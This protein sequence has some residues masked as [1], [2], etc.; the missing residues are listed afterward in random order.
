MWALRIFLIFLARSAPFLV[1]S[2]L[3]AYLL[4]LFSGPQMLFFSVSHVGSPLLLI[5]LLVSAACLALATL[6]GVICLMARHL[7]ALGPPFPS[8]IVTRLTAVLVSHVI[9]L[10]SYEW[11]SVLAL[12]RVICV[13]AL[14]GFP[15][16]LFAIKWSASNNRFERSRDAS[17]FR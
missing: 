4:T 14:A 8:A 17:P 15:A 5:C 7:G 6:S 10:A 2:S 9:L 13:I 12:N 1:E 16:A 3:E 11:W